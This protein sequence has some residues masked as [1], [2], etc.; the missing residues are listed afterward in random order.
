MDTP[1]ISIEKVQDENQPPVAVEDK[2]DT[3]TPGF[4]GSHEQQQLSMMPAGDSFLKLVPEVAAGGNVTVS[5]SYSL[6][7]LPICC[8]S[9]PHAP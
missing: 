8:V 6:L 9:A 4:D 7:K 1:K 2:I 5:T 3:V